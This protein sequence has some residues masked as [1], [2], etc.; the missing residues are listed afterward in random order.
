MHE[1][2]ETTV[3]VAR[4]SRLAATILLTVVV[5]RPAVAQTST[6]TTALTGAAGFVRPVAPLSDAAREEMARAAGG[7]SASRGAR[8]AKYAGVGALVGAAAGALYAL[9]VTSDENVTDHS[10][11]GYVYMAWIPGGALAGAVI[12]A[13]IGVGRVSHEDRVATPHLH[14]TPR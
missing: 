14:L 5:A 4:V 8:V 7:A 10:E 9:K 11:D 12:G 13:L 2:G 6:P 3:A 1:W